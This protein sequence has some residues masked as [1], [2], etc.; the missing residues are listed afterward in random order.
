MEVKQLHQILEEQQQGRRLLRQAVTS[1]RRVTYQKACDP[2]GPQS[3]SRTRAH[4][5]CGWGRGR[6]RNG[7]GEV[8]GGL[9]LPNT[10]P[11]R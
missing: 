3:P 6:T 10:Q 9:G 8:G 5:G 1:R 11:W 4:G 2:E 7:T